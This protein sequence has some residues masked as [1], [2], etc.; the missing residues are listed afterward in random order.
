VGRTELRL[1][2]EEEIR[3]LRLNFLRN[4]VVNDVG[5]TR[6]PYR[7]S[8][9]DA[10]PATEFAYRVP[11]FAHETRVHHRQHKPH[12]GQIRRPMEDSA[13]SYHSKRHRGYL[14]AQVHRDPH[15]HEPT[16][17]EVT[18]LLDFI[19]FPRRQIV[20]SEGALSLPKQLL[21]LIVTPCESSRS[22]VS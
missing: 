16:R 21:Q 14:A 17:Q 12:P 9:S 11:D 20:L 19:P 13:E 1:R 3:A 18:P 8:S 6:P 2:L 15:A 4:P 10:G 5:I 7:F 22:R